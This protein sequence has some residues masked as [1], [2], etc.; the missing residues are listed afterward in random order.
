MDIQLEIDTGYSLIYFFKKS[1]KKINYKG[2]GR[3]GFS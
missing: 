2:L 3:I 1:N